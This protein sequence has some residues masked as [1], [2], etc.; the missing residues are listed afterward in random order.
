M[1]REGEGRGKE[2]EGG[3]EEVEGGRRR[4]NGEK[5][6]RGWLRKDRTGRNKEKPEEEGNGSK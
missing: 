6:A 5:G 4:A 2:G 3:E 1:R